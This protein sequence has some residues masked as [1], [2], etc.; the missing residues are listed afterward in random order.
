M[1]PFTHFPLAPKKTNNFTE[2]VQFGWHTVPSIWSRLDLISTLWRW[3]RLDL[4][5]PEPI[6]HRSRF[7]LVKLTKSPIR[8][9][10]AR[11]QQGLFF[12]Q[13]SSQDLLEKTSRS[14]DPFFCPSRHVTWL[15]ANLFRLSRARLGPRC[16]QYPSLQ[17]IRFQIQWK[18]FQNKMPQID[19]FSFPRCRYC[20]APSEL[21]YRSYLSRT[22]CGQSSP[23]GATIMA[24]VY[25]ILLYI[26]W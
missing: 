2:R 19:Q 10:S 24:H 17:D 15:C 25:R 9:S 13:I 4:T 3:S 7:P 12:S 21:V 8:V 14:W 6:P 20:D 22:Q 18:C 26:L 23:H 11:R 16:E 5:F 1:I